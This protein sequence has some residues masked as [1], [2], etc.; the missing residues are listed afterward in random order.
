VRRWGDEG[1]EL[2]DLNA[3]QMLEV[4]EGKDEKR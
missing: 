1:Q 4:R 3:M 2:L